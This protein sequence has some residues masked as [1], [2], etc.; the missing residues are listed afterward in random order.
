MFPHLR[1]ITTAGKRT[2]RLEICVNKR[3]ATATIT[4]ALTIT[5]SAFFY[6]FIRVYGDTRPQF[7]S[8]VTAF[9]IFLW[10]GCG[11]MV[12]ISGVLQPTF[13]GNVASIF[14]NA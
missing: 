5:T 14:R 3:S 6:L 11:I 13:V 9:G 2:V 4:P 7:S 8:I 10:N 12:E 1:Q